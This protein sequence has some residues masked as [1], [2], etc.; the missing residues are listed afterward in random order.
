MLRDLNDG[1]LDLEKI[2]NVHTILVVNRKQERT[3]CK[4]NIEIRVKEICYK[5]LKQFKTSNIFTLF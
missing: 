5:K 1:W 2:R 3:V 4:D